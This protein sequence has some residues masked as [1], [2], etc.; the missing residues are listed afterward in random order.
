LIPL[1]GAIDQDQ[2]ANAAILA[3]AGGAWPFDE[4]TL[5]AAELAGKLT[6]LFDHPAKLATAASAAATTGVAD[7]AE[8]LADLVESVAAQSERKGARP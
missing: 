5:D 1:P 4:R 7:G 2:K 3:N 6:D 8:R